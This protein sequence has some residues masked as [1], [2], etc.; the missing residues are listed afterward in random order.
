[1]TP[2][3]KAGQVLMPFFAGTDAAAH[4]A[5][6]ERLHLAGSI[7]M[8]DNV[9]VDARKQVDPAAMA[10][11]TARLAQAARADGRT[12]PG[13]IGVDQEGGMV[14]RLG[15]PLTEWPAPMTYGA[16]GN[17]ALTKDAGRAMA[18]ELAPLGFNVDFAPDTDVTIGPADPT[19][20]ARSMSGYPDAAGALGV[21]FSQGMQESG[22]LPAV[23]HFPG[24][25]SV[26]VDSHQ[27]L[28]VQPASIADL[29]ARDWKPFRA[30]IGAGVPM[31]MTGHIAVPALEPGVPASLSAPTYAAL[32][33][34]GFN[35]VAV[36]DALNMAAVQKRYPD[37]SAAVAALAAGADLLLMPT[38]VAQAH[39]AIVGAVA[40]GSLPAARLDEAAQRVATMMI[41]RGRTAAPPG[42]APGAGADIS[43]RVSAAAVTVL[44]GP[45]SGPLV[46]GS[47]RVAGGS[48]QDRARFEAAAARAGLAVGEG[49]VVSL[50]GYGG[51]PAGGDIAVSLDAPW[52]LQDSAAPV[53]VA[54]YGRSP[55]AFDALAAVLAG[56]ATAPGK[57]PAAVGSFPAGTGCP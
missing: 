2:E 42:S 19:I 21:A 6:I 47:V 1:M 18:S 11:T 39:A 44:S 24:H 16:A 37:G 17:T 41:W 5:T 27:D 8:G 22:V 53:K 56:K 57:L 55:G 3:Q 54:L 43:A 13:L 15:S 9:P 26:T 48:P 30:A 45:C 20:G 12:W 28:P 38:D 49:P 23:K 25:G 4:A 32:R 10:A 40:G 51:A 35:G 29:E 50:I 33:G 31:V 52:P 36:T 46:P 7:I 14:A 34:M